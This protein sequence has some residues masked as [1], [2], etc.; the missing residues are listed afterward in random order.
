M[1]K[2]AGNGCQTSGKYFERAKCGITYRLAGLA[3]IRKK[4]P[5]FAS[6]QCTDSKS[7]VALARATYRLQEIINSFSTTQLRPP[8]RHRVR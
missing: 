6:L 4:I 7:L 1:P 5:Y 8:S 2:T 3:P